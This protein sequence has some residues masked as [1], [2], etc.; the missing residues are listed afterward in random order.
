MSLEAKQNNILGVTSGLKKNRLYRRKSWSHTDKK[1]YE[2]NYCSDQRICLCYQCLV[3]RKLRI[4]KDKIGS[5]S[6]CG[7]INDDITLYKSIY[8][9][10][11]SFLC[12]NCYYYEKCPGCGYE[13]GGGYCRSCRYDY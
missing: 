11:G 3:N 6:C 9:L 7:K 4:V 13:S 10:K 2:D 5:C 12:D 8:N 1:D